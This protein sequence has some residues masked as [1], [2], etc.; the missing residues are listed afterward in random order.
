MNLFRVHKNLIPLLTLTGICIY[1]L[2][3]IFFDKVYYEG[4]YYDR[5]FSITHYIGFVGV[6]LSLLVYFLKRSLF[7]PVLLVT[8]TMGL[9]NLAN[10]TLDKTSVGIGPIGIQP[11]S[12]LLI[13]IYY[14]LNK[15]SA[16]RFLRAYIIPSP[17]P[18]KQAENWRAQV[19]KF[20]ETFA[21]KSDESLQDMVQKRAVVP[22]AL[23][24][25]KQLLQERGIAVSNR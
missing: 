3:I 2:L 1:T 14:F 4:A 19:S 15:Q 22:A 24:A 16:H 10:F 9:F 11:L 18:Q 20:K 23:E 13:I 21:K 25:A 7:K 12:L 6:V 8:L 5:A 17:S